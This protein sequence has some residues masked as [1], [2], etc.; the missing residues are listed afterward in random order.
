MKQFKTVSVIGDWATSNETITTGGR[1]VVMTS[2]SMVFPGFKPNEF[3][4]LLVHEY[5]QFNSGA[6]LKLAPD[7]ADAVTTDFVDRSGLKNK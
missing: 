5:S 3:L 4:E 1:V 7:M 6:P 2:C